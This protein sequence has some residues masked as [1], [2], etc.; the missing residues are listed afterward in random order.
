MDS[1]LGN[2]IKNDKAR[3]IIY[4]VYVVVGLLIGTLQAVISD[5]DPYW[6][7][8]AFRGWAYLSIPVG[9]LAAV[10]SQIIPKYVAVDKAETVN[11]QTANVNVSGNDTQIYE[12]NRHDG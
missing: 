1:N 2:V 6:L 4:G 10:N 9:G 11:A 5:P 12:E 3:A 7:E 8:A